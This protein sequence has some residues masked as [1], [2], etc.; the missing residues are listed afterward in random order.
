MKKILSYLEAIEP[1]D[2]NIRSLQQLLLTM[3]YKFVTEEIESYQILK[4]TND[5]VKE[6]LIKRKIECIREHVYGTVSVFNSLFQSETKCMYIPLLDQVEPISKDLADSQDTKDETAT[7]KTEFETSLPLLKFINE[8][9]NYLTDQLH[10]H[11]DYLTES[12]CL[13]LVYCSFRLGDANLNYHNLFMNK[14]L[15][16]GLFSQAVLESAIAKRLELAA[17][18]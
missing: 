8:C 10:G 18:Y 9:T 7:K 2:T 16:K 15:E 17:R 6:M 3:R 13:Q 11:K 4:D 12:V 5:S 1:F 14:L